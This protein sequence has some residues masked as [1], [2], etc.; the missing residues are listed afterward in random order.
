MLRALSLLV[1]ALGCALVAP[2]G[3][4]AT[5]QTFVTLTFDNDTLSEYTL[6]FQQALQ[7]AGVNATFYVDSG[8]LVGGSSSKFMSWSQLSALASAGNDVGGKTVDGT[9]LTTLTAAQQIAE[10]CNDRQSLLSHGAAPSTFAY[11]GG[12]SNST[13]QSEVQG[14]GYGNA[15]TAGSLSPSGP[16]YAEAVPPKSWLGLRA[17]APAGQVTLSSLEAIVSGAASHGGGWVPVVINKVCSQALDPANYGTCTASAGWIELG[18]LQAFVSWVQS[19][20]QANGAPAGT[21]FR[22]IGATAAAADAVAPTTTISCN[23]AACQSTLYP[24]TVQVTLSPTDVGSGVASTHYT[25]DGTTPTLASPTYTRP[26][27]ITAS[28]TVQYRSW[29][30]AGNAETVHAQ[31]ITVQLPPD[32]TPPTTTISCNGTACRSG[33]YYSP[34]TVTLTATDNTGGWGVDKTYYTTGGSIPTTS[35]T[36]YTGPFSVKGPST[37]RFFST[38]LAGNVEAVSSQPLQVSTVVSLTFDDAYQNQWLYAVPLLRSH[39]MN[40]TWYVITSDS[41]VPYQCCMSWAEL[42]TLQSQGDDVGSHT[43]DHPDLTQL[44]TDQITQEVCGSRQDMINNGIQDPVSFAYPF[45]TYNSTVEG[46]V[47]QC[48]FTNARQGGGIS[49]SNTTPTAPYIETLPARDPLAVRTIAV[50]G[51]SP[52]TL[53]DLEAFVNAAASHGGGWLPLTFHNVCDRGAPDYSTCM[54]SYGPIDDTVLAQFLDWLQAAGQPG[55]APSGVVVQTMRAAMGL[56][57]GS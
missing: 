48:G 52:M 30:G 10:I 54:S 45:G 26:F 37:V 23:G 16:T 14:C 9:N 31:S 55:G 43:V 41:D 46:I 3:G 50:D 17:Y 25:T 6:G 47:Q 12:V 27:P 29:D 39:N 11:P 5:T 56:A 33:T 42:D 40:A 18:D 53:A 4:A 1:V 36:V 35:S 15:R 38:D 51:A 8:T 7:P 32:S 13:I 19:S 24:S 44:T 49:T 21:S 20:G 57:A 28:A 34:V 2:V 22:T